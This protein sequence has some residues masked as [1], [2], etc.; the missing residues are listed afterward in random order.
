MVD[1]RNLNGSNVQFEPTLTQAL[2]DYQQWLVQQGSPGNTSTSGTTQTVTGKVLRVSAV[3]QGTNTIYYV[4]I[5]GQG[6][7]FTANLALSP[8]LPLVQPGDTVTGSYLNTSGTVVEFK[9]FDDLSISLGTSTPVTI[10]TST[11]GVLPTPTP[12]PKR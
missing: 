11:P 1:A 6:K 4:Q 2:Q 12:T 7:I 5:A 10:P 8:K 3:Q 9:T